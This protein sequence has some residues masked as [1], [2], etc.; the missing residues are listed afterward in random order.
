MLAHRSVRRVVPAGAVARPARFGLRWRRVACRRARRRPDVFSRRR[1]Y[2][3]AATPSC[4]PACPAGATVPRPER[5]ANAAA[6]AGGLRTERGGTAGG[7]R[8]ELGRGA[9]RW[10]WR[11]RV[12]PAVGS[13]G[14]GHCGCG[15]LGRRRRGP[16][17]GGPAVGAAR[18]RRPA[19]APIVLRQMRL[20]RD[21]DDRALLGVGRVA[22]VRSS[23]SSVSIRLLVTRP[24]AVR[25][26][27]PVTTAAACDRSRS[28]AGATDRCRTGSPDSRAAPPVRRAAPATSSADC[29]RSS[30]GQLAAQLRLD[31]QLVLAARRDLAIQL[32][33]VHQ[34]QIAHLGLIGVALPAVDDRDERSRPPRPT[35]RG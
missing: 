12:L 24:G 21:V 5:A 13:G 1:R 20:G 18:R 27:S 7:S 26:R 8:G 16:P 31:R 35:A 23:A 30:D 11:G 22:L 33:V 28:R 32:Q 14:G 3:P 34:L 25:S 4:C 10:W 19:A 17:L 9:R 29:A 6:A 2:Q 15:D